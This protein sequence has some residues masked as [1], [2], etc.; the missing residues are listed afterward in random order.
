ME[1]ALRCKVWLSPGAGIIDSHAYMLALLGDVENAGGIAVFNTSVIGGRVNEDGV[2]VDT[3]AADA[4]QA[5]LMVNCAGLG[6]QTVAYAIDG[7]AAAHIPQLRYARGVYFS[8]SAKSP[9]S[10]LICPLRETA[11]LG[12]HLMIDM[13]GRRS[14]ARTWNG[15]RYHPTQ[16]TYR[17][18]KLSNVKS[19][20]IGRTLWTTHCSLRTPGFGQKS[21]RRTNRQRTSTSQGAKPMTYAA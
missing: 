1:P 7:F 14:S 9:F 16:W 10:H 20:N 13:G 18:P 19:A 15:S 11:G 8:I 6:A 21:T 17:G 12:V 2:I 5:R 4:I 3:N